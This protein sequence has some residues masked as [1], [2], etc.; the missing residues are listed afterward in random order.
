MTAAMQSAPWLRHVF[1][2][3]D[4]AWCARVILSAV[5]FSTKAIF[6]K[7]IYRHGL[8]SRSIVGVA[9]AVF[10]AICDCDGLVVGA[11]RKTSPL[12]RHDRLVALVP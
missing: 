8:D 11:P 12:L 10:A 9:D 5:A 3:R 7:L 4:A 1:A 6:A 2:A